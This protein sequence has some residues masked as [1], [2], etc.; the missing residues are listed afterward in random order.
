MRGQ[1]PPQRAQAVARQMSVMVVERLEM[2]DVDQQE[3]K[4]RVPSAPGARP[5]VREALVECASVGE[6]G[7]AVGRCKR[8]RACPAS[9]S[10]R[11]CRAPP[12]RRRRSRR[13]RG[14]ASRAGPTRP[15]SR[16]S[17][18]GAG[19]R[20]TSPPRP[21]RSSA[22]AIACSTRSLSSAWTPATAD[23]PHQFVGRPA[24]DA[25]A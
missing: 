3:R 8:A 10:A 9:P 6:P 25:R 2:I 4:L 11:S 22:Q 21:R 24:D 23:V 12:R 17:R 16:P 14:P 13:C 20:R 1:N 7:Q 15:R 5:F 18:D 19:D